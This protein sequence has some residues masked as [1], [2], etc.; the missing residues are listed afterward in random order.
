MPLLGAVGFDDWWN[1]ALAALNPGSP[2]AG[3][4]ALV[5]DKPHF[6][7]RLAQHGVP[8]AAFKSGTLSPS[9]LRV[10][11][12]QFGPAPI[13]KPATGAG[14]RGVYRYRPDLDI[15]DNLALYSQILRLGHIDSTT[16]IIAAQYLGDDQRPVEISVDVPV[17]DSRI[18]ALTIHEKRSATAEPP[19]IDNLMISP[20]TDPRIT[21]HLAAL[22]PILAA[23]VATL[24][25]DDATLHIELRLHQQR[26]HVLDVGVRPGAGLVAHAALA[27]TG[28]DPRLL[29]AAASIGQPLHPAAVHSAKGTYPATCIACC[30]VHPS[31][32]RDIRIDRYSPFADT[33]RRADDIIGWHLNIADVDDTIYEPDSGLSIGIGAADAATATTRM[34]TLTA[35]LHFTT[36]HNDLGLE[37]QVAP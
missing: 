32:R 17:C 2:L 29:H 21:N 7:A 28:V 24:D 33:L 11:V 19:Y 1:I 4:R 37:A 35:P 26:W 5:T 8:V 27:R 3:A 23:V 30:Y 15:D 16:T 31:L 12:D 18:S 22:T 36:Q 25:V 9:F 14:S 6:Y 13:L 10:A 34:H 20:P